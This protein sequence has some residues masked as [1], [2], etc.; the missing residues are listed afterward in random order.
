MKLV[1]EYKE[2]AKV[3]QCDCGHEFVVAKGNKVKCIYCGRE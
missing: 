3:Y 1:K 2:G